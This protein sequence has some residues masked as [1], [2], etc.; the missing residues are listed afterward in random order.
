[1]NNLSLDLVN[2]CVNM[3]NSSEPQCMF[4]IFPSDNINQ[5]EL[6]STDADIT[7]NSDTMT[8]QC[9]TVNEMSAIQ[10]NVILFTDSLNI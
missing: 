5:T 1:M 9:T 10:T 3:K 8:E 4:I 7:C 6:I 2:M